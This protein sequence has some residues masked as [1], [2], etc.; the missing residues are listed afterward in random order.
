MVRKKYKMALWS[1]VLSCVTL[2]VLASSFLLT[3]T[4]FGKNLNIFNS[5]ELESDLEKSYIEIE[6]LISE[7]ELLMQELKEQ[8]EKFQTLETE[9]D[10]LKSELEVKYQQ[11]E[12]LI[13]KIE[14]LEKDVSKLMSLKNELAKARKDYDKLSAEKRASNKEKLVSDESVNYSSEATSDKSLAR[15]E[16]IESPIKEIVRELEENI[17]L[18]NSSVQTYHKKE[19]GIKKETTSASKVNSLGLRYTLYVDKS[20]DKRMNVFYVQIFDTNNKNVGKTKSFFIDDKEL[21]YSFKSNVEYE[22][23]VTEIEEEFSTQG[24]NLDKGVYF[25]NIFSSKGKL[26][27]SRS[28]KLD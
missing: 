16:D 22:E 12:E 5:S 1:L 26:L 13:S 23:Q 7:K 2:I 27:S 6:K 25:L 20:N 17:R 18:L 14:S 3:N 21:V 15:K 28:F 11:V 4:S 19:S 24:L 8:L 9:N 10:S